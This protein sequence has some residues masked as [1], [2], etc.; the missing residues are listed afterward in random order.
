MVSLAA[1]GSGH[2][3]F[4]NVSLTLSTCLSRNQPLL[5]QIFRSFPAAQTDRTFSGV[6]LLQ[7]CSRPLI[8]LSSTMWCR[9][10]LIS[11]P[12]LSESNQRKNNRENCWSAAF[13]SWLR[14]S[15]VD[16]ACGVRDQVRDTNSDYV[17][18]KPWRWWLGAVPRYWKVVATC[19]QFISFAE[20]TSAHLAPEQVF[21]NRFSYSFFYCFLALE[22][23]YKT[24]SQIFVFRLK[25]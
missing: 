5:K 25:I 6:Q 12:L 23:V 17:M 8:L 13:Q 7:L 14:T 3:H 21:L 16:W 11:T 10:W 4:D 2:L 19:F 9:F 24:V 22:F 15:A 1:L 18:K 20:N